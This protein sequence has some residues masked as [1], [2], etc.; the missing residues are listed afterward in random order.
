MTRERRTR[1]LRSVRSTLTF[2]FVLL[3]VATPMLAQITTGIIS[4]SVKG[5]DGSLLPGVTVTATSPAL[6]GSRVAYT[7]TNGDY[8]LRGL[9][10]GQYAVNFGRGGRGGAGKGIGGGRGG[11]GQLGVQLNP[12]TKTETITV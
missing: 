1:L 7:G 6:Q 10:P 11:S 2:G 5:N 4:G 9:P 8:I 3:M 12:S